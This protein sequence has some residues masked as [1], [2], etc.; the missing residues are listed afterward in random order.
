ME[1]SIVNTLPLTVTKYMKCADE[2]E[3][4][5]ISANQNLFGRLRNFLFA[6]KFPDVDV[7]EILRTFNYA[8]CILYIGTCR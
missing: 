5:T 4:I 6:A 1:N 3:I 7:N 8:L 2:T